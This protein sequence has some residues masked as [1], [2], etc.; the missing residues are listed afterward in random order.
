[1][2]ILVATNGKEQRLNRISLG[3]SLKKQTSTTTT[4]Q[5]RE[6]GRI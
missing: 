4:K 1:M 6:G 3:K 5:I 2:K